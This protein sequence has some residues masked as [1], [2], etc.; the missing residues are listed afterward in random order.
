M[1]SY[2]NSIS[3]SRYFNERSQSAASSGKAALL[4]NS[5]PAKLLTVA[6]IA[7]ISMIFLNAMTESRDGRHSVISAEDSNEYNDQVMTDDEIRLQNI[8]ECISG[9]GEVRVMINGSESS[10]KNASSVFASSVPDS[11]T[12]KENGG[13]IVQRDRAGTDRCK[14]ADRH[15]QCDR[16]A[17]FDTCGGQCA[18]DLRFGCQCDDERCQHQC[19]AHQYGQ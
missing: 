15:G 3:D 9:A 1:K 16:V 17:H 14:A 12:K 5:L 6:L 11:G 13:V 19:K 18:V 7:V 4:K 10:S 2:N 8:L